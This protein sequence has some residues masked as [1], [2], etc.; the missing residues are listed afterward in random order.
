[1]GLSDIF[2]ASPQAH[3]W[4]PLTETVVI[5]FD[6]NER[7]HNFGSYY[8]QKGYYTPLKLYRVRIFFMPVIETT[9][10]DFI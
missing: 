8:I 1:V 9:A 7:P 6:E 4:L 5:D 3:S 10:R 2:G